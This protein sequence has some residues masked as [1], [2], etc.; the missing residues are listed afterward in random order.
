MPPHVLGV[1][2]AARVV[3]EQH[4]LKRS[5]DRTVDLR[6]LV[7][8]AQLHVDA[9]VGQLAL[10]QFGVG[11]GSREGDIGERE[12]QVLTGRLLVGRRVLL[13]LLEIVIR[14]PGVLEVTHGARRERT[15]GDLLQS[16]G[17]QRDQLVAIHAVGDGQAG[18]EVV[19]RG[20]R[21]VGHR[22]AHLGEVRVGDHVDLTAVGNRGQLLGGLAARG[23]D[24]VELTGLEALNAAAAVRHRP[25]F[26][27]VQVRQRIAVGIGLPVVGVLL[28]HELVVDLP[29]LQLERPRADQVLVAVLG[30]V[31]LGLTHHA[32]PPVVVQGAGQRRPR[33]LGR[34]HHGRGVGGLDRVDVV[35]HEDEQQRLTPLVLAPVGVEVVLDHL[36]GQGRSVV[37][38]HTLSDLQRPLVVGVVGLDRLG[39]HRH[40][41]VVLVGLHQRVVDRAGHLDT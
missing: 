16:A 8:R 10:D 31:Q 29:I 20:L 37:K 15:R 39:Q 25:V 35:E 12:R 41:L 14:E 27:L 32:Q 38:L 36:G 26:D 17:A 22:V 34:D 5:A 33:R 7:G 2:I 28:G 9:G 3:A 13:G 23:V 21:L 18:I 11:L 40:H 6:G 4:Q 24:D 30:V 19:E 1:W